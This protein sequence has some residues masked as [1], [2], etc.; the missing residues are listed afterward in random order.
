[1]NEDLVRFDILCIHLQGRATAITVF[2]QIET[3]INAVPVLQM[4]RF[5]A[6]TKS[7]SV[8]RN[9]TIRQV[10]MQMFTVTHRTRVAVVNQ[11]PAQE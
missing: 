8:H 1:M 6:L 7:N 9:D 11:V 3:D 5:I 10:Q 2:L 4:G